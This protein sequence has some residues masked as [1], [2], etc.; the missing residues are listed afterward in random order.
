MPCITFAIVTLS[1]IRAALSRDFGWGESHNG[2]R[3]T[4]AFLLRAT[5]HRCHEPAAGGAAS[6][7][8]MAVFLRGNDS[9]TAREASSNTISTVQ[10]CGPI[11]I[12]P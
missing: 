5:N 1:W 10:P 4:M 12:G 11:L 7:A 3:V 8:A 9:I 6:Y 2:A